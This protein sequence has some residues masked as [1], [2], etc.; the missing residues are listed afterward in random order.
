MVR[1]QRENDSDVEGPERRRWNRK[2]LKI[3][4]FSRIYL[5]QYCPPARTLK[6]RHT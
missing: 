1:H 6:P 2:S 4:H 5:Y 3:R